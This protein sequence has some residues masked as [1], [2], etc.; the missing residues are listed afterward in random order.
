MDYPK[1][2]EYIATNLSPTEGHEQQGYRPMLVLSHDS[3]NRRGCAIVMPITNTLHGGD[4]FLL[5]ESEPVQGA[6]LFAQVRTIDW[7]ARSFVSKG[8]ASQE[9]VDEA[10]ACL[11][12]LI[13]ID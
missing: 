13:D 11:M 7:R 1:R 12:T 4:R 9:V 10:A 3:M 5:P 6:V 8:M 2:G